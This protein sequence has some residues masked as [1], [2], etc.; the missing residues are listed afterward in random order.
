MASL[1]P[2]PSWTANGVTRVLAA[3]YRVRSP[4]NSFLAVPHGRRGATLVARPRRFRFKGPGVSLSARCFS[5]Q[6]LP[7]ISSNLLL[8][9]EVVC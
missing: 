2:R 9:L 6:M 1:A 7:A 3:A 8:V 5:G 4:P